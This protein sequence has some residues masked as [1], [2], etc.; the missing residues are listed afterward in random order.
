[1]FLQHIESDRRGSIITRNCRLAAIRSFFSFVAGREPRAAKLCADVLRVPFKRAPKRAMCYL[2]S[3]EVAAILSQPDQATVEGQRD[4]TLISVL[5]NTGARIQEALDLRPQD[6][7]L[8][9]P[10]HVRLIGKGQKE[11]ISPL[12]PE[13]AEVVA[14]LL[15]RS[16][17]RP[18]ERLFVNRYGDPLTASGFR[19]RLREYVRAAAQH[20][21]SLS[22]K[23]ITTPTFLGTQPLFTSWPLAWMSP[24]IRSWLGHAHLDTT[25]QYAQAN[26]ET[27]RKALEQADPN[28]R[29][30]KPPRWKQDA[31]LL[32]WLDSL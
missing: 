24:V 8:Q 1:M 26:L 4:H 23:R 28:L 25:N 31:D 13:T 20:F 5:Y 18:D 15:R 9:S 7:H 2:E 17:R 10:S 3:P 21:P 16:P 29:P 22:R 19:F 6:M 12:W 14:A 11:R 32:T 30:A 27:K